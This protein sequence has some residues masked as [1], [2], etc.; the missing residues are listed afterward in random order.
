M[1]CT[2]KT[3]AGRPCR[4]PALRGREVCHAHSG[5]KVG[6]PPALTPQVHDRLVQAKRAGAC[7]WVAAGSAGISETTY[8]ELLR[9]GEAEESGPHRELFEDLRRATADS[10]LP[11]YIGVRRAMASPD[12]WRA[13]LAVIDRAERGRFSATGRAGPS[14][15]GSAPTDERRLDPTGLCDDDLAY[16]EELYALQDADD[17]EGR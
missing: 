14:E 17:E 12:N 7:D 5:A 16:L 13:C 11:A 2:A 9:R 10:V 15:P 8:Y 1:T 3:R 6:R 4:R